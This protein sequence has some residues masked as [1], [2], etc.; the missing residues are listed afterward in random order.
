VITRAQWGSAHDS[1]Y[2]SQPRIGTVARLVIHH[3]ASSQPSSPSASAGFMR[4]MENY[5]GSGRWIEYHAV[6]DQFGQV[7]EGYD[8]RSQ[9]AHCN[10]KPPGSAQS[11]NSVALG[12]CYIGYFYPPYNHVPTAAALDA[13]ARWVVDRIDAGDLT[14]DVLEHGIDPN[15]PGWR[16][17]KETG[18]STACPGTLLDGGYL[19]AMM[20]EA[21]AEYHGDPNPG[22]DMTPEEHQ[23]LADLHLQLV[24][25][26]EPGQGVVDEGGGAVAPRWALGVAERN[27]L[28]IRQDVDQLLAN[29]GLTSTATA[30]PPPPS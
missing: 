5:G 8:V 29:A 26:Y 12:L 11:F 14:V 23:M 27:I 20:T 13:G 25:V 4:S 24:S 3:T 1:Y 16:G 6:I 18:A 17:H 7:F 15:N 2:R 9:G 22:D 30:A 21:A 28:A 19:A 10:Q